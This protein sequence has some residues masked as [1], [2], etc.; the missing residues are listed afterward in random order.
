[1]LPTFAI[2]LREGPEAVLLSRAAA[3]TTLLLLAFV[4]TGCGTLTSGGGQTLEVTLTD[5][6]CT[7]TRMTATSGTVTFAVANGGTSKVSELEVM[8]PNGVMLGEKENIV[9][10]LTG[11][12]TLTLQP[13]R[14]LLRCPNGDDDND[15]ELIVSGKRVAA[16]LATAQLNAAVTAYR[17]YVGEQVRLLAE[18]VN[19][20]AAALEAGDLAQAKALF[21]PVR[22][23][24]ERI[25]TVAESYGPLDPKIDARAGDVAPGTEWTGFH[26]I[27]QI[28]WVR[29]TTR[30]TE[31]FA[32]QLRADVAT[33]KKNIGRLFF[34]PP[35]LANGAVEL[36]DEVA[37]SKI[38]GEED[39]YS[40][41]DLSDFQ[42]NLEGARKAFELLRP[43]LVKR[44]ERELADTIAARFA[45][46]QAGLDRYRRPTPLGFALYGEL[47]PEDRRMFA[48]QVDAVAEPLSR[49]AALVSG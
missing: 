45:T 17:L 42:G 43:A 19:R 1:V 13:G 11:S 23:Y 4:A 12:F 26:R 7:P 49:V 18:G 24:Y 36:L 9:G 31:P 22:R 35:Q 27:E 16:T 48:Q 37:R 38:T 14:Y 6:G 30:G 15:G 25:E 44:G 41:T 33:L 20:F 40:H 46:V 3:A 10:P 32:E 47:T 5:A 39:R 34:Q 8:K 29:G 2:G 28:L 21:G